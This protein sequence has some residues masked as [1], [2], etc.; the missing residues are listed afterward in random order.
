M[1]YR[2]TKHS[3]C[4]TI[5]L[6]MRWLS[7]LWAFSNLCNCT[8]ITTIS[9]NNRCQCLHLPVLSSHPEFLPS[10]DVHVFNSPCPVPWTSHPSGADT[11]ILWIQLKPKSATKL[12]PHPSPTGLLLIAQ[13]NSWIKKNNQVFSWDLR[14]TTHTSLCNSYGTWNKCELCIGLQFT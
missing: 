9:I 4:K 7:Q 14:S 5:L 1:L 3:R 11:Q 6:S 2:R 10:K 12:T 13:N 8:P